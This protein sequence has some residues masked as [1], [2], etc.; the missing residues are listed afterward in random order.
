LISR[1]R[2]ITM[3]EKLARESGGVPT[4]NVVLLRLRARRRPGV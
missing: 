4:K 1:Y 3:A 2:Y